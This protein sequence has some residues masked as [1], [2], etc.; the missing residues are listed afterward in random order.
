MILS[1]PI[2]WVVGHKPFE[3]NYSEDTDFGEENVYY[4]ECSRCNARKNLDERGWL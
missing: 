2:C 1:R 3:Y 4:V